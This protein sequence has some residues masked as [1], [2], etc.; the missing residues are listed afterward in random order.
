MQSRVVRHLLMTWCNF[1]SNVDIIVGS[2]VCHLHFVGRG[3]SG[4]FLV[5][6]RDPLLEILVNT[7][8]EEYVNVSTCQEYHD[9]HT[10]LFRRQI[11]NG[12]GDNC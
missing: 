6:T 9:G 10:N 2:R 11:W 3:T 5:L 7:K 12:S 1:W 8:S 4:N